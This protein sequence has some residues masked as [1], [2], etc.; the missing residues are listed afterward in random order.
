MRRG[1]VRAVRARWLAYSALEVGQCFLEGTLIAR[2][3]DTQGL[4]ERGGRGHA[5]LAHRP[6]ERDDLVVLPIL[7]KGRGES[8]ARG[9]IEHEAI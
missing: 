9:A 2:I 7:A 6:H 8:V 3:R 4:Q 5:H 1:L